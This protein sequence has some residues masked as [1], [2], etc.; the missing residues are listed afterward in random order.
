MSL[1]SDEGQLTNWRKYLDF[2]ES[3]GDY[4]RIAFLYE[5]CLVAAAHYDEFWLR[6]ARWMLGQYNK[7][8]EVRHIFMRASCVFCPIARPKIR[9][10]WATFEEM[11]GRTD[12]A[13]LIYEAILI[14]MPNHVDTIKEWANCRRRQQGLTAAIELLQSQFEAAPDSYTKATIISEWATLRWLHGDPPDEVRE[15]FKSNQTMCLDQLPFWETWLQFETRQPPARND[16]RIAQYTRCKSVVE[17]I[18]KRSQLVPDEVKHLAHLYMDYL[19]HQGGR[20]SAK[21]YM[22]LDREVNK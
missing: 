8:E 19:L 9:L 6:Y 1:I 4:N 11:D 10:L 2:E 20:E 17:D 16:E 22:T 7:A 15:I 21:E 3:E 14:A 13:E 12:V 5:R 18:R